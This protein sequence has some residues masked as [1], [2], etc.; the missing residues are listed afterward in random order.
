[1]KLDPVITLALT[2]TNMEMFWI[3][4]YVRIAIQIVKNALI[5]LQNASV[6]PPP[7]TLTVTL[8][9]QLVLHLYGGKT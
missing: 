9:Y 6:A 2:Q 3:K 4:E 8:V 1:M 7:F 5:H